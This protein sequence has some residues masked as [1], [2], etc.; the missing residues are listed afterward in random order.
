VSERHRNGYTLIELLTVVAL[1]GLFAGIT[2][3]AFVNMQR[4]AA[5]RSA[6]GQLRSIFH[7]ARSRALQRGSNS[8]VKFLQAGGEWQYAIYDDG[9]GDGVRNDDIDRRVDRRVTLPR[10]ALPESKI[11]TIGLLRHTI[12]DPDGD[13]LLPTASPVHF[14]RSAI[15]S[16]T[17]LGESTPGTIYITDRRNELYAVRVFGATAKIR[18]LRY[19]ATSRMWRN[20]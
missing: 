6:A 14:N 5:L 8:G 7:L 1:L 19:D 9:D 15:C 10:R 16:F 20:R 4:R 12:K 18:T 3:P 2:F 17:P 11:V 13:R